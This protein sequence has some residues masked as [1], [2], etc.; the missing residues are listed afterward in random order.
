[1]RKETLEIIRKNFVKAMQ[2]PCR[3]I[4][5]IEKLLLKFL[6]EAKIP[7]KDIPH[8]DFFLN[9]IRSSINAREQTM[10]YTELSSDIMHTTVHIIIWI[11]EKHPEW[12]QGQDDDEGID[13]IVSSRRKSLASELPKRLEK[14]DKLMPP[15][16]DDLFGIRYVI[17]NPRNGIFLSCILA[18]KIF[19]VLCN[20]SR[21]DRADFI[22]FIKETFNQSTQS[23][24]FRVL[25]I[26]FQLKEIRRTDSPEEFDYKN[27]PNFELPTDADRKLLEN[28][29][30][31]MKFY[32]DPKANGYQSLHFVL[33][34]PSSSKDMP[35]AKIEI[36]FRTEAMDYYANNVISKSHKGKVE[37]YKK[38]F[39][40]SK[41]EILSNNVRAFFGY[42][43]ENDL[44]GIY[45]AK[46]FYNRRVNSQSFAKAVYNRKN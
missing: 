16:I 27:F 22:E 45:N 26:P 9:G 38:Y 24:I 40:L 13:V 12:L 8:M 3:D 14:A 4:T 21:Q 20:F 19:N 15:T 32:F 31:F 42:S 23:R 36:Q 5:D 37:K 11:N 35:G 29:V 2:S 39:R 28:L 25:E 34:I 17:S 7:T 46:K 30:D 43:V 44:D 1:M 6:S 41:L 18:Q 33:E 10:D